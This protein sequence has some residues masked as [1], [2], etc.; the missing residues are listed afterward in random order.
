MRNNNL[1]SS[2]ALRINIIEDIVCVR[3]LVKRLI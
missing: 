3:F 1:G 2:R